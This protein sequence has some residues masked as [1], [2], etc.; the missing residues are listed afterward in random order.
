MSGGTTAATV[1]IKINNMRTKTKKIATYLGIPFFSILVTNGLSA[2]IK[3]K[4][5][6]TAKI[7]VRKVNKNHRPA[8]KR[9]VKTIVRW[10]ISIRVASIDIG[11]SLTTIH[12]TIGLPDAQL[13]F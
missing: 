4:A 3:I 12:Y 7:I 2:D 6:K 11:K 8:R 13:A 10:E 5:I 1:P 9:T